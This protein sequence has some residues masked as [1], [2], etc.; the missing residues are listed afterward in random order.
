MKKVGYVTILLSIA[1]FMGAII[2]IQIS[3][4]A[5]TEALPQVEYLGEGAGTYNTTLEEFVVGRGGGVYEIE[6]GTS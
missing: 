4:S 2:V 3:V 6:P 1:A 5:K